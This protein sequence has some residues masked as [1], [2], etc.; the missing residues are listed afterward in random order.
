MIC[1][2]KVLKETQNT[3]QG[4]ISYVC[5]MLCMLKHVKGAEGHVSTYI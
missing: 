4:L 5:Q 3:L 1:M 2:S